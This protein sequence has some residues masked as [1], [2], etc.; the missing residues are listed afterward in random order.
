MSRENAIK[1]VVDNLGKE[2]IV[3]ATTGMISR[4]L[5]EYREALSQGHEKDFLTV[6]GMGHASQIAFGIALQKTE[7]QVVCIDGDGA[8]LMHMGSMVVSGSSSLTGFKHIILNNGAHDSV[9]G[10]P[11]L[12]FD[13]EFTDIAK[14][15]GYKACLSCHDENV[16]ASLKELMSCEG[17]AMLEIRVSKGSRKD[18]GRP[19]TT[20]LE[21][22]Q[23]FMQYLRSD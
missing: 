4:E 22:K 9:G 10:Q 15:A 12:G 16:T 18:L 11:T 21:N 2:D 17:P 5:F 13:I 7:K 23:A 19:T 14:S 1:H 3:V 20:P 8:A 6:G